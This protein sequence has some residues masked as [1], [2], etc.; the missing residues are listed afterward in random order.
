MDR[1]THAKYYLETVK[2]KRHLFAKLTALKATVHGTTE[3]ML[4]FQR[5]GT[6][7]PFLYEKLDSI[8]YNKICES[9]NNT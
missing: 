6:Q 2:L 4:P 1:W 8:E 5:G 7:T 3:E 9:N